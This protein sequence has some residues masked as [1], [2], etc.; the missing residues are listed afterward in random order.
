MLPDG[1]GDRCG[2]PNGIGSVAA[3]SMT[4]TQVLDHGESHRREL[5]A[6]CY[7]YFGSWPEAEDAVQEVLVKA[8]RGAEGFR[9]ASSLRTWLYRIATNTCLDMRRAPQR[10]AL[11]M[12]LAAPGEVPRDPSNLATAPAESWLGPIADDAWWSE[13]PADRVATRD[14]VRLAFV[15]ALQALP[16][17]QRVVLLLREVLDWSAQDCAELLDMTV[18]AVTSALARARR[19]MASTDAGATEATTTEEAALLR[20]YVDAFEAYD[21]DRLVALLATD[22]EFS[23]PPYTLWLRGTDSIE[24]W[25]RG[26]GTVCRNSRTVVTGANGQPA[27]AVYHPVSPGRWEPFAVHVLG[28]HGARIAAITH[29]MGA[30]VFAQLGL[31]DHVVEE[32]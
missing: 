17:R 26:P 22:A 4:A 10:R 20:D 15:S 32:T 27:V 7:R 5:T 11:P 9:G 18:D 1:E 29:F 8:R 30:E 28:V 25:W 24:T 6:F 12:D 14:S 19:T 3:M 2:Q 13:D 16:P 23:M 31:P 21:V